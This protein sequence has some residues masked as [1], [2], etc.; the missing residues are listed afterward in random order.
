MMVRRLLP[1][2]FASTLGL[3]NAAAAEPSKP[4]NPA[5]TPEDEEELP[6]P[7]PAAKDLLA[8][9]FRLS[10]GADWTLPF[11]ML[12]TS[13]SFHA[14]AISGVGFSGQVGFG[15]SRE[16]EI[17]VWGSYAR[18]GESARCKDCD[19]APYG[20]GAFLAFHPAQGFRFDPWITLGAGY[21]ALPASGAQ[22]DY[23]GIEW[24]RLGIG[25]DWYG[26][27]Q[28]GLGPYAQCSFGTFTRHDNAEN[29]SVYG[30]LSIGLRATLD[31]PG[32]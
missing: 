21:R 1:L 24:L 23:A 4:T 3:S 18:L 12:D 30:L 27:S 17:G 7:V 28:I 20:V 29:N 9:H 31:F 11:A 6:E 14:V 15:L 26:L 19:R 10:L 32:K 22:Q 25:G 2:M 16:V 8:G 13:R 5:A